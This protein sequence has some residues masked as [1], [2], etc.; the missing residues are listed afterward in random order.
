MDQTH[1]DYVWTFHLWSPSF[2]HSP[3]PS[4]PVDLVRVRLFQPGSSPGSSDGRGRVITG[5]LV[6]TQ[7]TKI[8]GLLFQDEWEVGG[9][10]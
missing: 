4:Y 7:R 6:W 8:R 3:L 10:D 1:V 9:P 2:V 5:N